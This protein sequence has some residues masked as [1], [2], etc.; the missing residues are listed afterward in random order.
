MF[1]MVVQLGFAF[2]RFLQVRNPLSRGWSTNGV[3]HLFSA[4]EISIGRK[5]RNEECGIEKFLSVEIHGG[6][7]Y[8]KHSLAYYSRQDLIPSTQYPTATLPLIS[9]NRRM[10]SLAYVSDNIG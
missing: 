7:L 4:N 8:P 2:S 1:F 10:L 3:N 6:C 9:M 5:V